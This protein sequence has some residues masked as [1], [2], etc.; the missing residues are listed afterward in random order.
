MATLKSNIHKISGDTETLARDYL[1]LFSVKQ[2]EKLALFLGILTSVFVLATLL[3]I[4]VVFSSFALAGTLNKLLVSDFWGFVIVG[5]LYLLVIILLIV[6]IFRTHTPLFANLFVK[7]IVTVLDIDTD[8]SK[9][10]KGLKK[11]GEHIQHKIETDKTKIEA[12][13]Q[14]LRYTILDSILKEILGLFTFRKRAKEEPEKE[15]E[16][17]EGTTKS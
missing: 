17:K 14:L 5:G 15:Q 7:L 11:E 12:D 3:L 10:I 4:L 1:K 9:S 2:S 6:K 8:Q 16:Q 13:F